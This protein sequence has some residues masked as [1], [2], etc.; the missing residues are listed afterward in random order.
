MLC[1]L[2]SD[3]LLCIYWEQR[4]EFNSYV[5]NPVRITMKSVSAKSTVIYIGNYYSYVP[6]IAS[7]I[8]QTDLRI[9]SG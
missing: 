7:F 2:R 5:S 6:Y 4:S 3:S 9:Y 8:L 1:N